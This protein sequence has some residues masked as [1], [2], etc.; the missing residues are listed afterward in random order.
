MAACTI[1]TPTI[2]AEIRPCPSCGAD[3][4]TAGSL[5]SSC[6]RWVL[7]SCTGCEQVYLENP[8][9]V[10]ALVDEY[11]WSST[12][13]VEATRRS[14]SRPV[15]SKVSNSWKHW[16]GRW[17]PRRQLERFVRRYVSTGNLLDIGCGTAAHFDRIPNSVVPF[18]IEIDAQA[19]AAARRR[20]E[21]RGGKII[22]ADALSGLAQLA[23]QS[24][25]GIV[26][27]SFLEHEVSPLELLTAA[28]GVLK[29]G[30]VCIIKVPNLNCWNRRYW[31]PN[32]W[33]GFRFPDHVNYFTPQTLRTIVEK[34]GLRVVRFNW[35]DR[36]PTSDNMWL[37]AGL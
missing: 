27:H 33:P 18:G 22:H 26:M 36:I 1:S 5:P 17:L 24:M 16:R 3:N 37:V 29:P 11:N 28:R 25:D 14:Q 7:K 30:G 4:R 15:L 35:L 34:A 9:P 21:P 19:I 31:R 12:F 6:G 20:T 32:D 8:P 10:E 13:Q 23:E 2:H